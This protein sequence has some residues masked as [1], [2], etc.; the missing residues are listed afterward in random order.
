MPNKEIF[1]VN[2]LP[3]KEFAEAIGLASIPEISISQVQ[4]HTM[5]KLEKLK[6]KIKE[7]KLAKKNEL[8]L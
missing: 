1:D 6:Q 5:T 3:L 8:P 2:G 4:T 7:K